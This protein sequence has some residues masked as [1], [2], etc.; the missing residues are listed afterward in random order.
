V[1]LQYL[2]TTT[3]GEKPDRINNPVIDLRSVDGLKQGIYGNINGPE[4]LPPPWTAFYFSAY[5]SIFASI[6][7]L[8]ALILLKFIEDT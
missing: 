5:R 1:L 3:G 8:L 2:K 4:Q 6:S 7:F